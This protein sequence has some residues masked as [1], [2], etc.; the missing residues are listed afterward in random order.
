VIAVI[1]VKTKL[2]KHRHIYWHQKDKILRNELKKRYKDLS[3]EKYNQ[4]I[5]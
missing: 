1:N 2:L 4:F 5:S 3:R